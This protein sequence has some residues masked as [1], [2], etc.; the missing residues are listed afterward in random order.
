VEQLP[1]P[2]RCRPAAYLTGLISDMLA[3]HDRYAVSIAHLA[4]LIEATGYTI[5]AT[6]AADGCLPGGWHRCRSDRLE[7]GRAGLGAGGLPMLSASGRLDSSKGPS[8]GGPRQRA[9]MQSYGD[10]WVT[11][12]AT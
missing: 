4:G 1:P 5:E 10:A 6:G 3:I 11:G 9:R 7:H 2:K 8:S 12:H